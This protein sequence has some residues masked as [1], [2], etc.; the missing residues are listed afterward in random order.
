MHVRCCP[1]QGVGL[2]FVHVAASPGCSPRAWGSA[3][4]VLLLT[5]SAIRTCSYLCHGSHAVPFAT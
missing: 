5:G 1:A 4:Y 3:P 2:C